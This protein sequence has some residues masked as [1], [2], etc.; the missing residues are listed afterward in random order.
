MVYIL[1]TNLKNNSKAIYSIANLFGLGNFSVKIML[2]EL[3]IGRNCRVSDLTQNLLVKILKW[4]EKNEILVENSLKQRI[5]SNITKL[6]LIKT[7]KGLRHIYGLPVRGQ[8]TKTN[9]SSVRRKYKNASKV[10]NNTK[11]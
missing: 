11:N 8:R 5:N 3:N 6:K 2:N 9:A 10:K 4:I 7:Y 1:N